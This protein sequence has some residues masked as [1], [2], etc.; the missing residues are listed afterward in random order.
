M[1][2]RG[3]SGGQRKRVN[4]GIELVSDPSLLFL[5][6]PTSGLDSTASKLVVQVSDASL[7][8]DVYDFVGKCAVPLP[9]TVPKAVESS[10]CPG[11]QCSTAGS[12]L[13]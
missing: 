6:E 1:Q 2:V 5:D 4:V 7:G 13:G 3:I 11:S 12:S 10:Y 8:G 9:L